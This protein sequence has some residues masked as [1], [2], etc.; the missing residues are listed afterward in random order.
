MASKQITILHVEDD[1]L[2][3]I[4]L[5]RS[6]RAA[7]IANDVVTARN[8]EEALDF[9]RGDNGRDQIQKPFVMLIDI[10]MP[11]MN[12]I[13]LLEE[14]R[15]DTALSN[16]VVFILTTS[17]HYT[18]ILNAYDLNIAGYLLKQELGS[19]FR[20]A[21]SVLDSFWQVIELPMQ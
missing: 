16:T 8:G 4:G 9:L 11:R 19:E 12:G 15:A 14:I 5:R 20:K 13:E 10:N 2:D 1:E 3:I 18:D 17:D 21:V 6:L 7:K